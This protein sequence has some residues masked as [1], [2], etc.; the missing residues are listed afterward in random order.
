MSAHCWDFNHSSFI[1]GVHG[2]V[3]LITC[4]VGRKNSLAQDHMADGMCVENQVG[5]SVCAGILL[6]IQPGFEHSQTTGLTWSETPVSFAVTQYATT[7]RLKDRV[8]SPGLGLLCTQQLV[9]TSYP[10]WLAHSRP[11][12][13]LS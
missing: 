12:I 1:S 13:S 9:H 5:K 3:H 11:T 8:S 4:D 6:P 2:S 10:D 7:P